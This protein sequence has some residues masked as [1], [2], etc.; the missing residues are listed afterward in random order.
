[1]PHGFAIVA[2]G[3]VLGFLS[4][5]FGV[6]GSSLATPLLRLLDVS[7]LVA[8]AT[9]LPV[10]FPTALV[11]GITYW[12]RGF[13]D[14]RAA[15]WVGLGGIPAVIAGSLLTAIVPGRLLM[16]LTGG[17]VIAVGLHLLLGGTRPGGEAPAP[18]P[19][20]LALA[21]IGSI[22]GLL[23]GLL[24]NGGGFLLV[25]VNLVLLRMEAQRA[26]A[27][28]LVTI[29]LLAVPGTVVHCL[30]GHID[31][32]L[33][34]LLAGGMIPSTYLG[35]RVGLALQARQARPLFGGFLLV[36]GLLFL[37]RTLIRVEIY[38]WRG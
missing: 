29:A 30:L 22:V 13:V 27:T 2:V 25:P 12:R 16:A 14:V 5:L 33:A 18:R 21:G 23:S 11:G 32:S 38:G 24:A 6:G 15:L 7:R 20:A 37:L 10:T 3:G 19:R 31:V 36:F 9:P 35:A 8:L 17:L 26:A 28:S 4:G 34:T 1:M